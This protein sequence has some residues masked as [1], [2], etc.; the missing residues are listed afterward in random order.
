MSVTKFSGQACRAFVGPRCQLKAGTL[1]C[2]GRRPAYMLVIIKTL[3][4]FVKFGSYRRHDIVHFYR[5]VCISICESTPPISCVQN[6]TINLQIKSTCFPSGMQRQKRLHILTKHCYFDMI[7]IGLSFSE[8]IFH[9]ICSIFLQPGSRVW[10]N[11]ICATCPAFGCTNTT[12]KIYHQAFQR[13][14][15]GIFGLNPGW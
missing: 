5:R 2:A 13:F 10:Q 4:L 12:L 1:A 8:K 14:F 11:I 7:R 15:G 9:S 3:K 6:T